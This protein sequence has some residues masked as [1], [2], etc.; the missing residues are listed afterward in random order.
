MTY[1]QADRISQTNK[2][3]IRALFPSEPIYAC[4][5]PAAAQALIGEVGPETKGVEKMLRRIGFEY[6]G[7][8]DPF[9]GGPHFTARTD[10]VTL[11]KATRRAR[12]VA[13][14]ALPAGSPTGLVCVER[15]KAPYFL[16][17]GGPIL[18]EGGDVAIPPALRD[19]LGLV[20][21]EDVG[22]LPF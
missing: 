19:A 18:V 21:G 16:A 5:L 9:D 15:A 22:V 6:G 12:A 20:G 8:I 14:D 7:R 4:L 10:D 11:V 2:E 3:F 17:A 1:Q 13:V